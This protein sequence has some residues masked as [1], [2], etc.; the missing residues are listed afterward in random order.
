MTR[1]KSRGK[2]D[3]PLNSWKVISEQIKMMLGLRGRFLPKEDMTLIR[4][5]VKSPRKVVK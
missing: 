3:Y 5:E 1:R 2:V 4:Y